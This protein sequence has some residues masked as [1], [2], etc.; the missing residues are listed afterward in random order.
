MAQQLLDVAQVRAGLQQ[1]CGKAVTQGVGG[2]A[3][4]DSGSP[5]GEGDDVLDGAG[6]DVAAF[7]GTGKEPVAVGK[8]V[9]V[10]ADGLGGGGGEHGDPVLPALASPDDDHAPI[11][12]DVVLAQS[13]DLAW[14]WGP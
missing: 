1:M 14:R 7:V 11:L 4:R 2:Q 13:H 9:H 5:A 10:E 3:F 6:A 8:A 12:V